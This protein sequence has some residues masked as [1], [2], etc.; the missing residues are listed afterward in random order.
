MGNYF[1][2][3]KLATLSFSNNYT[4]NANIIGNYNLILLKQFVQPWP[5]NEL[6]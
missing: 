3:S 2:V 5:L 4:N 6:L 1:I